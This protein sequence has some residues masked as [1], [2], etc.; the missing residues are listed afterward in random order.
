MVAE[1]EEMPVRRINSS[2][3][4]RTLAMVRTLYLVQGHSPKQIEALGLGVTRQ[5]VSQWANRYEWA[6]QVR[7]ARSTV[8]RVSRERTQ[9]A[10]QEVANA[11]ATESEEL[12]FSALNQTRMGLVEGGLNGAKQAQAASSTLR[13][14]AGVAKLLRDT[15]SADSDN[16]STNLNVFILR[17]GDNAKMAEPKRVTEVGVAKSQ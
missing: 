4:M 14:L 10:V 8:D 1:T 2:V 17:A 12:C 13:N 15:G 3:D 6:S 5:Q 11:I 7:D 16:K 9:N